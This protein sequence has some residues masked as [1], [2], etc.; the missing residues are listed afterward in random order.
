[1]TEI[2][3]GG[4]VGDASLLKLEYGYASANGGM[5][6]N[7]SLR[8]Q[9]ITVP[10]TPEINQSYQYDALNRISAAKEIAVGTTVWRQGFVY[11]RYGNRRFDAASTNTLPADNSVFNPVIDANTNRVAA[12]QGY[13]YDQEGNL[14]ANPHGMGFVYNADNKMTAIL[15][16]AGQ[17]NATYAYDGNGL[18]VKKTV[19][20]Q[21]TFFVYDAFGKLLAEYVTNQSSAPAGTRFLTTDVVGSPR[22]ATN[23]LGSALSRHD[24]LPFGEEISAGVAGRPQAGGYAANDGVRQQFAGH[25]RDIESGLDFAQNRYYASYLGRFTSVDPMTAS[26][27]AKNPQ[28]LNRYSYALNSPYKF[29]DPLGLAATQHCWGNICATYDA[30]QQAAG[31]EDKPATEAP[32]LPLPAAIADAVQLKVTTVQGATVSISPQERAKIVAHL[33]RVYNSGFREGMRRAAEDDRMNI[34]EK[35]VVGGTSS[36]SGQSST[37]SSE[38][39]VSVSQDGVSATTGRS[40]SNTKSSDANAEKSVEATIDNRVRE[41]RSDAESLATTRRFLLNSLENRPRTGTDENG[42]RTRLLVSFESTIKDLEGHARRIGTAT[43]YHDYMSSKT[44]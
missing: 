13:T 30:D 19:G 21:E 22:L 33:T 37:E 18:R 40:T 6:N 35:T 16:S 4:S 8:S 14:T 39:E 34:E 7:G 36:S 17:T 32:Q 41:R 24:Y 1:L 42:K 38:S 9:K 44:Y 29:I 11:D 31:D 27:N 43:G 5:D 28:T 26:A 3:V 23:S 25:Q 20:N 15:D 10:Y 12:G 2:A